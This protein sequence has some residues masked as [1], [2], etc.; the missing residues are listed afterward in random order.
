M[1]VKTTSM[2]PGT[3]FVGGA[4]ELG[5]LW[6]DQ[7]HN[8]WCWYDNNQGKWVI[9]SQIGYRMQSQAP[10]SYQFNTNFM[11]FNGQ[12]FWTSS[13]TSWIIWY[14]PSSGWCMTGILGFNNM[15]WV[16]AEPRWGGDEWYSCNSMY[17]TYT[18]RGRIKN[19]GNNIVV[20]API[21]KAG[22]YW[23]KNGAAQA[24]PFGDY[25]NPVDGGSTK[26]IG[27]LRMKSGDT[28]FLQNTIDD[29]SGGFGTIQY[30]EPNK[31]VIGTYQ[32]PQGWFE[33]NGAFSSLPWNSNKSSVTFV[34]MKTEDGEY[35]LINGEKAADITVGFDSYIQGNG[36]AKYYLCEAVQWRNPLTVEGA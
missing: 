29:V 21:L 24:N 18:P 33:F 6:R 26:T 11:L 15:E 9:S 3:A 8:L 2:I 5:V 1:F 22:T 10:Y 12:P 25:T 35:V 4:G 14:N 7:A 27:M 28:M 36:T 34:N 31:W 16:I 19:S 17:G 32:S 30:A 13:S 20:N 23:V